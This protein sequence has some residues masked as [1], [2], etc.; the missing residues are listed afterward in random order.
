[1]QIFKYEQNNFLKIQGFFTFLSITFKISKNATFFK[2]TYCNFVHHCDSLQHSDT[3]LQ[4]VHSSFFVNVLK[5]TFQC[6]PRRLIFLWEVQSGIVSY[7][8]LHI[9]ACTQL[10]DGCSTVLF[11][12]LLVLVFFYI[13]SLHRK[14][15]NFLSLTGVNDTG[16]KIVSS[17]GKGAVS[18]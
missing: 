8:N 5:F 14:I 16:E 18:K 12:P 13:F 1:M 10:S 7:P 17:V 11:K 2:K 6:S 4:P 9:P 3:A 15:V